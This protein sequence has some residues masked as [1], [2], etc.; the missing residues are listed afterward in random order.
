MSFFVNL[1][2]PHTGTNSFAVACAT[3]GIPV[4]HVW[5]RG[6]TDPAALA[7]FLQGHDDGL[8]RCNG[9]CTPQALTD[10]PFYALRRAIEIR[11]PTSTFTCTSRSRE[12]WVDSMVAHRNAGGRFLPSHYNVT[13]TTS[14]W[15]NNT[16][17][18][19][20]LAQIFDMH[21]GQEC[22]GVPIIDLQAPSTVKWRAFCAS[23]PSG[24]RAA[25]KARSESVEYPVA[26][27]GR[28]KPWASGRCAGP[29]GPP[30]TS[31]K[32]NSWPVL[33]ALPPFTPTHASFE[34]HI[35]T[36]NI[37]SRSLVLD[38]PDMPLRD[39]SRLSCP[40]H[41]ITSEWDGLG[42]VFV[43]FW[44]GLA[45]SIARGWARQHSHF[46]P[47]SVTRAAI[48]LR[49]FDGLYANASVYCHQLLY[50]SRHSWSQEDMIRSR[51]E[52]HHIPELDE[53]FALRQH[54]AMPDCSAPFEVGAEL[55]SDSAAEAFLRSR[56][57]KLHSS[58]PARLPCGFDDARQHGS[59]RLR[60][61]VHFRLGDLIRPTPS[62]NRA[63]WTAANFRKEKVAYADRRD[64]S[65]RGFGNAMRVLAN[66]SAELAVGRS[67]LALQVLVVSDSSFTE[68]ATEVRARLPP[69]ELRLARY[70]SDDIARYIVARVEPLG[71]E[72][73]L[74]ESSNPLLGAHCLAA[75][76]VQLLF[77]SRKREGARLFPFSYFLQMAR[78]LCRGRAVVMQSS[79]CDG[80]SCDSSQ[81]GCNNFSRL[82]RNLIGTAREIRRH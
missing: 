58:L 75:A 1:G 68:L 39:R 14:A 59:R 76:D 73:N 71:L 55:H 41:D 27:S 8:P 70:Y 4:L 26:H 74:L 23:V 77:P 35:C 78:L 42:H 51:F 43:H 52:C 28:E 44:K 48:H 29:C 40:Y 79:C 57:W 9:G 53:W 64:E 69:L 34:R 11:Y 36:R 31:S 47:E 17:D 45:R 22:V 60:V 50:E 18:R 25:C 19:L 82:A 54:D 15:R 21:M 3:V 13:R 37:S 5:R 7:A 2:L 63:T 65:V 20:K 49:A 32:L 80:L 33:L 62:D 81:T 12:A 16:E 10:T 30:S 56:Y 24:Y 72:I 46:F 6:E 66:A 61:S 67:P 38:C